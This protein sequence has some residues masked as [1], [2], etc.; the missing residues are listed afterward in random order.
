MFDQVPEP[1][2]ALWKPWA[3]LKIRDWDLGVTTP[4]YSQ[5]DVKKKTKLRDSTNTKESQS[6]FLPNS[7]FF[8]SQLPPF[9]FESASEVLLSDP[10][11]AC[12][13]DS[14]GYSLSESEAIFPFKGW[15]RC[16]SIWNQTYTT[17][18]FSP[19]N[20]SFQ[21]KCKGNKEAEYVLGPA[22]PWNFPLQ[23]ELEPFLT[24][25]RMKAAE[26]RLKGNE[27]FVVARCGQESQFDI[28]ATEPL[29]NNRRHKEAMQAIP[30][31][32]RPKIIMLLVLD[33]FS[34][35]HFYQKLPRTLQYLSSLQSS[36]YLP[37]DFKFHN[38]QGDGSVQNTIPIFA[39]FLGSSSLRYG[40]ML[41]QTALWATAKRQGYISAVYFEGCDQMFPDEVGRTVHVDHL[42]R[43]FMCSVGAL[44]TYTSL[45]SSSGQRCV[46]PHMAHVY[47][48]E[49]T[50]KV[51]RMYTGS[52]RLIY[53]HYEAA[54]EATGLHAETIDEDL[55]V[56]LRETIAEFG[57]DNDLIL[58]LMG[59]H[60][61]R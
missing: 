30:R 25:E 37:L 47:G 45:K 24:V 43:Q 33:S 14:F 1:C 28:V 10:N 6:S 17:F 21:L 18:S 41:N 39:P 48:F 15:P 26:V 8:Q 32:S 22:G 3:R 12:R 42:S 56:Y 53:Q 29:Y 36:P 9:S 19:Q 7:L 44:G 34:R 55:E 16:S 20:K 51:M 59:D 49:Y 58:Y 31:D 60:G 4:F 57:Q 5:E 27:D 46:G 38:V 52:N 61:M 2:K 23:E 13:P 35:R 40:D 50:K 54:H 11:L